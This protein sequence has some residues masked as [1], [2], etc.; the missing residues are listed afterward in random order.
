MTSPALFD[1]L[2]NSDVPLDES[3]GANVSQPSYDYTRPYWDQ[4][5]VTLCGA[6]SST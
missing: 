5:G 3:G 2:T 1:W 6:T 4:I